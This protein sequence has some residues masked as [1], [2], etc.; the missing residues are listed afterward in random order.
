MTTSDIFE[1]IK[2]ALAHCAPLGLDRSALKELAKMNGAPYSGKA[3]RA[4][5]KEGV[6]RELWVSGPNVSIFPLE[7]APVALAPVSVSES[8]SEVSVRRRERGLSIGE[9]LSGVPEGVEDPYYAQDPE[10]RGLAIE[11]TPCFGWF[12]NGNS[13]C[14]ACPLASLCVEALLASVATTA[15]NLEENLAR[16]IQEA[17]APPPSEVETPP[18]HSNPPTDDQSLLQ[19]LR[20]ITM[21]FQAVCSANC[22]TPISEGE[23]CYNIPGKGGFHRECA[24][25]ALKGGAL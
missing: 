7:S 8:V 17:S 22:G 6:D 11:A 15:A 1:A 19:N 21:P 16:Q 12:R 4:I 5:I 10:L 23:T 24:I 25:A 2:A 3:L 9:L 14:R 20:T 13:E 18:V